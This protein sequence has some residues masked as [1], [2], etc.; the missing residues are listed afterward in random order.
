MAPGWKHV[1]L[2]AYHA[3]WSTV[4]IISAVA[5]VLSHEVS[6]RH[7]K[8]TAIG[9]AVIIGRNHPRRAVGRD[10][11]DD[12]DV[13]N[14]HSSNPSRQ[15]APHEPTPP[16]IRDKRQHPKRRHAAVTPKDR[17]EHVSLLLA[18]LS[19]RGVPMHRHSYGQTPR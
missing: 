10:T 19:R 2:K 4:R 14:M 8:F 11:S 1:A 15:R 12:D 16:C 3:H 18:G 6:V 5:V 9:V 17:P 7:L 13:R